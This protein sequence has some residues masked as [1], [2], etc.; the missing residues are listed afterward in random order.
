M[1]FTPDFCTSRQLS[2][3]S[4]QLRHR[5]VLADRSRPR[6]AGIADFRLLTDN[7]RSCHTTFSTRIRKLDGSLT[8]LEEKGPLTWLA[9]LA[10]LSPRERVARCPDALHRE[11]GRVRGYLGKARTP[12]SSHRR[13]HRS[14]PAQVW[15]KRLQSNGLEGTRAPQSANSGSIV[16]RQSEDAPPQG[17]TLK[18]S[19]S[20]GVTPVL[21]PAAQGNTTLSGSVGDSNGFPG[22]LPPASAPESAIGQRGVRCKSSPSRRNL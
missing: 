15:W 6:V 2:A 11:A 7:G 19:N 13:T 4:S 8:S 20:G 3:I 5:G 18:G 21:R 12:E 16:N 1:G 10:T 14:V 22:A 9:T 17:P